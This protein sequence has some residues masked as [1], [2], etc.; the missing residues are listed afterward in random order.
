[1]WIVF[2]YKRKEF[3]LLRQDFRKILGDMPLFFRPRYKYQKLVKNKVEFLEKY[4]LFKMYFPREG[5]Y[6]GSGS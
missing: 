1:M 5:R 6:N 2:K 4:I 3:G